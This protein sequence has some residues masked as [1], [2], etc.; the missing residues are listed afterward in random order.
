MIKAKNG[1]PFFMTDV[2]EGNVI[3]CKTQLEN[4]KIS[5]NEGFEGCW[6]QGTTTGAINTP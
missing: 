2:E 6:Y 5:V 4:D 3:S 1:L